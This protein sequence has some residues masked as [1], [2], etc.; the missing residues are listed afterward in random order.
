VT[1]PTLSPLQV[2]VR[3]YNMWQSDTAR[4]AI[5]CQPAPDY[6]LPFLGWFAVQ[7]HAM[8]LFV[9][10][11]GFAL[12]AGPNLVSL[13][14]MLLIASRHTADFCSTTLAPMY[15]RLGE[16][17]GTLAKFAPPDVVPYVVEYYGV[18]TLRRVPTR[19]VLTCEASVMQW[20]VAACIASFVLAVIVE[21]VHRRAFLASRWQLLGEDGMSGAKMWP[22][23]DA[24]GPARCLGLLAYTLYGSVFV[25]EL[26]MWR[27]RS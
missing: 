21:G 4:A 26:F 6:F 23:G 16:H 22:F 25:S 15:P 13:L 12:R 1:L 17:F 7:S 10:S 3:L 11:A 18:A 19:G 27:Y 8:A 14:S 20:E 9:I 2:A 5:A 24:R